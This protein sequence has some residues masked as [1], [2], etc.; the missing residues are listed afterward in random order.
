MHAGHTIVPPRQERFYMSR[1]RRKHPFHGWTV[2]TSEKK[3]KQAYNRVLRRIT[4]QKLKAGD[5]QDNE[6]LPCKKDVSDPWDMEKDGK[7]RFGL[8]QPY[9][10]EL[11]RK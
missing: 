2:A 11:M 4:K 7:F 5:T 3:E 6:I 8:D 1:N 9:Y 10:N